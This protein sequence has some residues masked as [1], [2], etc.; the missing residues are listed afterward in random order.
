[1]AWGRTDGTSAFQLDHDEEDKITTWVK[2]NKK[3]LIDE[4]IGDTE[5]QTNPTAIIMAGIP[6]A[7]KTEFLSHM[8]PEVDEIVVIDLDTIVTKIPDYKPEEYYQYRKTA[9][10][11]ISGILTKALKN[12][13]NFALDGTFS[14]EK[15]A[16]NIKRALKRDYEVNLF[17]VDQAPEL[18]WEITK[19]RRLLTGRP[20]EREGFV[21]VCHNVVPNIQNAIREFRND[22]NFLVS[23][24]KKDDLNKY[25]YID[26]HK[27][28]DN[29]LKV[30]YS[31]YIKKVQQ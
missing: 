25:E 7:G 6:G 24:I 10:I 5:P 22:S 23:V 17:F 14:H 18:A 27:Q 15:G 28:V 16:E 2:K 8:T 13:L 12:R 26:D 30:V 20:I 9:N 4:I 11:L 31:R 1:M 29:Y 19:A 3:V 21:K